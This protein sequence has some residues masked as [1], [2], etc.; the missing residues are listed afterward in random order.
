[1]VK[2]AQGVGSR[3]AAMNRIV[4]GYLVV[5]AALGRLANRAIL[6]GSRPWLTVST[7]REERKARR[8]G[9]PPG[10]LVI[11]VDL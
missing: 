4:T 5:R 1:M 8:S 9:L 6:A 10:S 11:A 2:V 3:E 7:T